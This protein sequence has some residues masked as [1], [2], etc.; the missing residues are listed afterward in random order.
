[1]V[2]AVD[3]RKEKHT[4]LYL[5]GNEVVLW[6]PEVFSA[7]SALEVTLGGELLVLLFLF[8]EFHVSLD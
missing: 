5:S 3:A 2:L 7:G 4:V 6:D 1:M 8:L